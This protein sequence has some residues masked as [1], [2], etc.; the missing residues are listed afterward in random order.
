MQEPARPS[1]NQKVGLRFEQL[2]QYRA[3]SNVNTFALARFNT[4][5]RAYRG[6]MAAPELKPSFLESISPWSIS[7]STTPKP[8]DTP[9]K[10]EHESLQQGGDHSISGRPRLSLRRYPRDCP[11]LQTRLFYAVD[12]RTFFL[13]GPRQQLLSDLHDRNGRLI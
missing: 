4:F 7:R 5:L 10:D 2:P 11:R 3:Q 13:P 6:K 9:K 8:D 1:L 12:V